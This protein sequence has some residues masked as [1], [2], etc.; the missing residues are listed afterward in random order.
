MMQTISIVGAGAVGKTLAVS[1]YQVGK[2]VR[3][4]RGRPTTDSPQMQEISVELGGGN[5][6]SAPLEVTTLDQLGELDDLVVLTTKSYSNQQM[7]PLLYPKAKNAHLII[8][9]NGLQVEQPFIEQGFSNIYR[10]VLF[11]AS[12]TLN[13]GNVSYRQV[14]PSHLGTIKGNADSLPQ[15]V[16]AL[17]T[18]YLE[19]R[20]DHHLD[21]IVWEKAILNTV[22]NSICPLL[23][24]DNGIFHR[25]K[26][27]WSLVLEVIEECVAVAAAKGINLSSE[28]IQNRALTISSKSDGQLIST[29]QDLNHGRPTEIDTLNLAIARIAEALGQ[30][31]LAPKTKIL[32]ELIKLMS[33]TKQV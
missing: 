9:Q 5:T 3:L 18:H 29:Q 16:K 19:F 8:L 31:H 15:I 10:G 28:A 21:Q 32:G 23:E 22:F 17:H 20:E 1:L 11:M 13:D 2:S 26:Q 12:E 4:I 14:A 7:A 33:Q 24:M 30:G 6:I 25:N 27:V